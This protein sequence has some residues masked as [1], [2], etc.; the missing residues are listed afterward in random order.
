M[1]VLGLPWKVAVKFLP[2][3]GMAVEGVRALRLS[4]ERYAGE[5][6]GDAIGASITIYEGRKRR[7]PAGERAS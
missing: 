1:V 4:G 2:L 7:R 3:L 6:V 5:R